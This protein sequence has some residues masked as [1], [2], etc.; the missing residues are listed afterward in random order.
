MDVTEAKEGAGMQE[1]GQ[2]P[3]R[4]PWERARLRRM[5]NRLSRIEG[6]IKGIRAML[7]S[8]RHC[9][10]VL[11]QVAAAEKGLRAFGIELAKEHF[12]T[13]VLPDVREGGDTLSE[14]FMQIFEQLAR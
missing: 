2:K 10:D 14:E 1:L 5:T 6:Q 11:N 12:N 3:R 13:C 9:G 4:E 8:D 7:E